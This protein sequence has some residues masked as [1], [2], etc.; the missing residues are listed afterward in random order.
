MP[1]GVVRS[2]DVE[3]GLGEVAAEDGT[4]FALHCTQIADGSRRIEVGTTVTFEVLA[5]LGRFE[6]TDVRPA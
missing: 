5:K 1:T 3:R 6:A 4:V 2:Y